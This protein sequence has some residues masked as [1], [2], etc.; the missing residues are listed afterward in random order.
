MQ[1]RIDRGGQQFGPY[2]LEQVQ[3]HL[4]SG[5]LLPT[6]NAWHEGLPG[7]VPLSELPGVSA[8][9]APKAAGSG[10]GLKI[11][12]AVVGV[13]AIAALVYFVVLPMFG[14]DDK[15]A[16]DV[17]GENNQTANDD[18][19]NNE[20]NATEPGGGGVAG[21]GWQSMPG[22]SLIVADADVIVHL[23]VGAIFSSPLV[24][25][26]LQGNA[27]VGQVIGLMQQNS[28]IGPGDLGS[29]TLSFSGIST[30]ILGA[31]GL[32]EAEQEKAIKTALKN[33]DIQF[34]IVLRTSKALDVDKL[35]GFIA[36]N[37]EKY[38]ES[39]AT[40]KKGDAEYYVI[41]NSDQNQPSYCLLIADG[42]T[43]VG[44]SESSVLAYMDNPSSVPPRKGL[45]FIDASQQI[46][47]AYA[48]KDPSIIGGKLDELMAN[49]PPEPP[50]FK[51]MA[52]SLK[53]VEAAALS[54][55]M[56]G[57]GLSFTASARLADGDSAKA[58]ANGFN[59]LVTDLKNIPDVAAT[60]ATAQTMG[61]TIPQATSTQSQA[62][63]VLNLPKQAVDGLTSMAS[64]GGNPGGGILPGPGG[65]HAQVT[66]QRWMVLSQIARQPQWPLV[67]SFTQ[68]QLF[69]R[70]SGPPKRQATFD[71]RPL[72]SAPNTGALNV[73][74]LSANER[75]LYSQRRLA[76]IAGCTSI[77]YNDDLQ[78]TRGIRLY[79]RG[80]NHQLIGIEWFEA[81]PQKIGPPKAGANSRP[82]GGSTRPGGGVQPRPGGGPAIGPG[83]LPRPGGGAAIDP[84]GLPVP[85]IGIPSPAIEGRPQGRPRL[86]GQPK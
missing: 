36:S 35:K 17:S 47:I 59:A 10:K 6:D 29:L 68:N 84:G 62:K 26:Q 86:K 25:Q 49:I 71:L 43:V 60:L 67:G 32:S 34:G 61:I 44:G 42:S 74:L 77:T 8:A 4:A 58:F 54:A 41:V 2:S 28:G 80:Q 37:V 7:W 11:A 23:K 14:D 9:G 81:G 50:S 52:E 1:I 39:F 83:G 79:F 18:K 16:A 30:T 13:A 21:G 64:G 19:E 65:S 69:S 70:P 5:A 12:L 55:A 51:N 40:R 66:V 75:Q 85:A 53:K 72:L 45:D 38:P 82:G 57:N 20:N 31:S 46:S 27:Q 76:S 15:T 73:N 56:V 3:E 24:Q 78:G 33:G 22:G 48:P 63:L